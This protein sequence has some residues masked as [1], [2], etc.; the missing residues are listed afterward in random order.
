M[1]P[2]EC[3]A[4]RFD[5]FEARIR[6]GFLLREDKRVKIEELPF[7]MLLVLL[8]T[9]GQV[10]TKKELRDRLWAGKTFGELDSSLH[11]AVAKLR[12]ALGESAA[13]PRLI[14]TV[15]RRGY[16]FVGKVVP[17][18]DSAPEIPV[19]FPPLDIPDEKQ[20]PRM[21]RR[22]AVIA[23]GVVLAIFC[24]ALTAIFVYRS[25]RR[26]LAG[27]Q[28]KVVIGAFTNS[29]GDDSYSGLGR[30]FRVKLDES[31]Y[32]SVIADRQFRQIV[33]QNGPASLHDELGAC[34]SLNGK[35]LLTG[36]I[37]AEPQGYKVSATAWKCASGSLLVTEE[38]HADSRDRV[39]SALN[40]ATEQLRR[41]L[42]ESDSSLQKFNVP[43]AQATTASLAAL[44]AFTLGEEKRAQGREFEAISDYKLAVD[45]DPQFALGYA[46][47][48]TIYSN[49]AE[50][51]LGSEYFKKAFEL[52]ERTTDR[53]RLYIAAHYYLVTTGEI[54][55]SI[56]AYELW[57]SLYPRD[58]SPAINLAV[59]YLSI[60]EADKA[61]E[62]ARAAVQLDASSGFSSAT[63]ARAYLETANYAGAENLCQDAAPGKSDSLMLHE[64]CFLLAFVQNDEAAMQ[65]Q[66]DWGR[67]NPAES[68]LIDEAAWVAMYRGKVSE[69]RRLFAQA[70]QIALSHEFS[71]LAATVDLDEA[72]L[73]ADF[74]YS[75]EARSHA[76]DAL[77][78][79]PNSVSVQASAAL[80]LARIGDI[81]RAQ[82]EA[83]KAQAQSPLDTI[84]NSGELASVRAAVQLQRHDPEAAVQSLEETRPFDFC[85]AMGLAPAYYR[86]LAYF[87][88]KQFNQANRE[89]RRVIDHR[90]LAPDSPYVVLAYLGMGQTLER[91]G[92]ATGAAQAYRAA[93]DIWKD[94]DPEFLPLHRLTSAVTSPQR[95]IATPL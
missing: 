58:V 38:A 52:R 1:D 84:L 76:L 34:V 64:T 94:A 56:D 43:V 82:A 74:G 39:L 46:R 78:L 31:P 77:N 13:A 87:Q 85:E 57:R 21:G 70:R 17:V 19:E 44:K 90:A 5:I 26:P 63:L 50:H 29:T 75:S 91:A 68:A 28:D 20:Y 15:R 32:L 48:G 60:G 83:A 36:A 8:E 4:Y 86:G 55:R 6:T 30:A 35:I 40:L 9:P 71:E 89:F 53:E 2:I 59:E 18:F 69:G 37:V 12:E 95:R 23:S 47:L 22:T 81:S 62:M 27:N 80:A 3:N 92:D 61:A 72:G 33:E 66:L 93:K 25:M 51:R 24:A 11:V 88:S 79:A 49:A 54:Q 65:R 10:V 73:D 42:G 7:Q 45:L 67:G 16:Q 41:R 14:E